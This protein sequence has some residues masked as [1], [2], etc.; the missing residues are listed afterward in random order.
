MPSPAAQASR[1]SIGPADEAGR[2]REQRR[3]PRMETAHEGKGPGQE[4]SRVRRHG[5]APGERRPLRSPDQ[6]WNPKMKSYIFVER[7][8]IHIIDLQQR[9]TTAN[10][11]YENVKERR[12]RRD[13]F[14]RWHQGAGARGDRGRSGRAGCRSSTSAGWRHADRLP[15]IQQRLRRLK[16]LEEIDEGEDADSGMTKKEGLKLRR[17]HDKL[18]PDPGWEPRHKESADHDVH[19]RHPQRARRRQ[20]T[21]KL[22]IPSSRSSTPTATP[23]RS[24]TPSR[25][26]TTPSARHAADP[27]HRRVPDQP[28]A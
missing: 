12:A 8:G 9:S 25:P 15:S 23:T 20:G 11:A 7:N 4:V 5:A 10:A 28:R 6:R 27:R 13:R 1:S 18:D 24:T 22:R 16:E 14:L 3:V 19:H 2:R 26:T 17:E 21:R